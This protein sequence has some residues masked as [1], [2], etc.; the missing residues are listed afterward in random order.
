M[1]A[2]LEKADR[3]VLVIRVVSVS[4]VLPGFR[5]FISRLMEGCSWSLKAQ[6]QSETRW[7]SGDFTLDALGFRSLVVFCARFNALTAIRSCK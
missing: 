7:E 3:A 6:V 2:A 4:G 1:Y 5:C